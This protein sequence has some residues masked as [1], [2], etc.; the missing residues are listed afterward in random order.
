MREEALTERRALLQKMGFGAHINL[1]ELR[2]LLKDHGDY[3]NEDALNTLFKDMDADGDGDISFEEA[4]EY[5]DR[6][7]AFETTAASALGAASAAAA[8]GLEQAAAAA[9]AA[10]AAI[11]EAVDR[12][13]VTSNLEQV[14]AAVAEGASA[15]AASA[16]EV[17][18]VAT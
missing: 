9:S 17:C 4:D 18:R 6:P 13:N 7:S 12:Y 2:T 16:Y 11:S 8:A 10:S 5:E 1:D 14:A 3:T 15:A